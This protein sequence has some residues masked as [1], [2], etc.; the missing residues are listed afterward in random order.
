[1]RFTE[2]ERKK[3]KGRPTVEEIRLEKQIEREHPKI[4]VRQQKLVC[5]KDREKRKEKCNKN[6][7]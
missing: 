1:M 6:M 3:E 7:L 5:Q 2:K 4:A